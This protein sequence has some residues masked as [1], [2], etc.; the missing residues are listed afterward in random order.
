MASHRS[1]EQASERKSRS[2]GGTTSVAP[3]LEEDC[4]G[5]TDSL[6][7]AGLGWMACCVS[8]ANDKS[9]LSPSGHG[10]HHGQD[11][12]HHQQQRPQ[13]WG[14]MSFFVPLRDS[15]GDPLDYIWLLL[16]LLSPKERNMLGPT[17]SAIFSP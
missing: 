1:W 2:T 6:K 8:H 5:S 7:G 10:L 13:M 14:P 15:W 11:F 4:V 9:W 3:R 17:Y 12:H 16:F